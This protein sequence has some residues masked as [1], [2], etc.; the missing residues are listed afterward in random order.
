M[1]FFLATKPT[2]WLF[3]EAAFG[4]K[5]VIIYNAFKS[6]ALQNVQ[7]NLAFISFLMVGTLPPYRSEEEPDVPH[8]KGIAPLRIHQPDHCDECRAFRK[9]PL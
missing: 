3:F 8:R 2:K 6:S 5:E 9:E 1:F 7:F 4:D